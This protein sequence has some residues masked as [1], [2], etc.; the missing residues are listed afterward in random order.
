MNIF[1]RWKREHLTDATPLLDEPATTIGGWDTE[2]DGLHL[3]LSKPFLIVMGFMD[4]EGGRVYTY[5]PTEKNMQ[6]FFEVAKKFTIFVAHNTKY[7]MHMLSNIGYRDQI[8][9]MQNLTDSMI[10]ARLSFQALSARDGGDSLKLKDIAK[11]YVDPQAADS[12]QHIKDVAKEIKNRRTATLAAAL[13][14]FPLV[15]DGQPQYTLGGKM[16]NWGVGAVEAFLKNPTNEVSDLPPEVQDV[17]KD[18][19]GDDVTYLEIYEEEPDMMIRYAQD[20]VILMLEFVRQAEKIVRRRKQFSVWKRENHVIKPLFRMERVGLPVDLK[21]LEEDRVKVKNYIKDLRQKLYEAAG[22]PVNCNQHKRI[23]EIVEAKLGHPVEST[24]Q[25]A[26]N[27]LKDDP[28]VGEMAKLIVKLRTLEKWYSTYILRIQKLAEHDGRFYSQIG[29]A[30][31]VSGR[32]GS[33]SQ[34]FPKKGIYAEDGTLLFHPRRVF[35]VDPGWHW[36]LLD[37]SQIE[38]RVQANYTILLGAPDL[39]LCR[40]YM[41]YRCISENGER[42]DYKNQ[43]HLRTFNR[44]NWYFEEEPDKLWKATDVHAETTR[45]ALQFLGYVPDG[46]KMVARD[47][48]GVFGDVIDTDKFNEL[49]GSLGKRYNFSKNYG[50]GI[51]ATMENLD[52]SREVAEALSRGYTESFPNVLYYQDQVQD[53]HLRTGYVTNL[54]GRRYY[55]EA[56]SGSYKLANYLIQGSCADDLKECIIAVDHLLKDYKS[57]FVMNVH[58]ELSFFIHPQEQFLVKKIKGIMEKQ[59]DWA[60]VPIVA[61]V[62]VTTTNWYEKRGVAV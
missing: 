10:I 45:N 2:T 61:D 20:D 25:S 54:F 28:V 31:A 40:A 32:V 4:A 60:Y 58:D 7:D 57:K 35:T 37:F 15:L 21:Q 26:L 49:R 36:Y 33:D 46:E 13:K 23:K 48:K 62:E 30:N 52:V 41:P 9:A 17:W 42:F 18:W 29:Q 56:I 1:D 59:R 11:K 27:R 53:R 51:D 39:N 5:P 43:G 55:M 47:G 12:E 6:V 22:E 14:Q 38:L 50:I 34:Q 16:K 19:Q 3:V 24:D 44:Q 8:E